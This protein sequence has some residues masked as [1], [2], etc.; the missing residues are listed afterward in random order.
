VTKAVWAAGASTAGWAACL[1]KSLTET[2]REL[3]QGAFVL[4]WHY[5]EMPPRVEHPL[6]DRGRSPGELL[7]AVTEWTNE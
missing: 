3:E 2:L 7:I 5:D 6:T 1:T 4:G